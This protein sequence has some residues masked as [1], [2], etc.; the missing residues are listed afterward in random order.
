M[1]T[2]LTKQN[3]I[4]EEFKSRLKSVNA[5]HHLA[6]NL[7]SSS[8]LNKNVKIKIYRTVILPVVLYGY[9]SWSLT[10][11]EEHRL[12]V[13]QNRVVRRIFGPKRYEVTGQ[14]RKLH[15][16]ELNGLHSSPNTVRVIK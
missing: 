12:S 15:K 11:K 3:S 5:C 9:E 10:F 6:Q 4:H 13:F 16:E 8:L 7:L 14:W 1:G 2:T